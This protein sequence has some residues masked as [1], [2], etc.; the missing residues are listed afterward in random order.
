PAAGDADDAP[1]SREAVIVSRQRVVG[2]TNGSSA[3]LLQLARALTGDGWRVRFVGPSPAAFG[4][5]PAMRLKPETD[6]FADY[7]LRG[8]WRLGRWLIAR[9]LRVAPRALLTAIE[10]VLA[11]AGLKRAGWVK[12]APYAVAAPNG[13]EDA[14]F[15]ARAVRGRVDA[16]LADYAF[17]APLIPYALAPDAP[18]VVVMHDLFSSRGGAFARHGATDSVARLT[19]AEEFAL[20]GQADA[21]VAIQPD[22]AEAVR[23]RVGR[24]EVIVAPMAVDP[25]PQAQPGDG[26][27]LLFVG[28]NTAPNII[29]LRWFFAE[30]WPLIRAARPEATLEVAGSVARGLREPP[31]A[32]VRLLGLVDDL[33]PL[34]ARAAVVIS[35]LT[36]GSGLKIKLIE[37]LGRGKAMVATPVTVQGVEA[38]VASAA[39]V[40]SEP[41][42][43]AEAV[44]AL[45]ADPGKRLRLGE[46]ALACARRSFSPEACWRD[47]LD[48]M[49]RP[50]REDP[51]SDACVLVSEGGSLRAGTRV[52]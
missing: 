34:Y 17:L 20:L 19:A 32:G 18:G 27:A 31:P 42:A 36:V 28:S 4:R 15:V 21:V 50:E 44:L 30:A 8:A 3:Y 9:D 2:E 29:G 1:A 40:E 41:A 23:R 22:E 38:L 13:R 7:R 39:V 24:T 35:P 52:S 26:S 16:V 43:F 11:R 25:V 37:A 5:W 47:L 46:A 10:A 49:V 51:V 12:A 48:F 6:V 45:L 33:E 14:L